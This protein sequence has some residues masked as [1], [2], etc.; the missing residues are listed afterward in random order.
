MR[1]QLSAVGQSR[2][3]RRC[4]FCLLHCQ[5]RRCLR[6]M[7]SCSDTAQLQETSQ[8]VR[9]S[10]RDEADHRRLRRRQ[11]NTRSLSSCAAAPVLN[12]GCCRRTARQHSA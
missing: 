1:L 8:R 3:A 5:R 11:V 7:H 2:V 6:S 10:A 9:R 4:H 12:P